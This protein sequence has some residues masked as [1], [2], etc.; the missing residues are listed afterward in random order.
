MCVICL[1]SQ[2]RENEIRIFGGPVAA[3]RIGIQE[4]PDARKEY[5]EKALTLELVGSLDEAVDH[6]HEF[7]SSHTECIVTGSPFRPFFSR[8]SSCE[9]QIASLLDA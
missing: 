2:L 6:I 3:D 7:G 8:F 1:Q 4:A 9:Q 5:G